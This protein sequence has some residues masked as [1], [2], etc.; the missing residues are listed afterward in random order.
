MVFMR[1]TSLVRF[2]LNF[3]LKPVPAGVPGVSDDCWA[4]AGNENVPTARQSRPILI[5]LICFSHYIF[6]LAMLRRRI[7]KG[8]WRP[9]ASFTVPQKATSKTVAAW[10]TL[11]E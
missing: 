10:A 4:V 8:I 6:F 1:L 9:S 11:G 2:S 3:A 5:T 7:S